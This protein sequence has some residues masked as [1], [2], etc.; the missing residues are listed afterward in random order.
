MKIRTR[1]TFQFLSLMVLVSV[2]SFTAIYVFSSAYRKEDF[3]SRLEKKANNTAKL[4]LQVDEISASLLEKIE[5]DNPMSLPEEKVIII[6]YKNE[7]VFSTDRNKTIIYDGTLLN[8]IRLERLVRFRQGEFELIGVLFISEYDRFVVIAGAHD[9]FGKSKLQNLRAVLLIVTGVIIF[10]LIFSG[11]FLAG[12]AIKPISDVVTRVED[13]NL[14]SLNVRLDVSQNM[15]EIDHLSSTFNSMLDRLESGFTMQR[16]FISNA[17]HELRTPLT[18]ITGQMEVILMKKRTTG[19][20]KASIKSSLE[21][22][23]DVNRLLNRL[24]LLA[25]TS[26]DGARFVFSRI[27]VDE[28]LWQARE[29]ILKKR[30]DY[31]II[32]NLNPNVADE[33]FLTVEGDEALLR[34]SFINLIDNGCKYSKDKRVTISLFKRRGNLNISFADNGIGIPPEDESRVLS[35]FKRGGNATAIEGHGIGLSLVSSIM[36]IHNAQLKIS[37]KVD[38][39]TTVNLIFHYPD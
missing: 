30:E 4:L 14:P 34:T 25:Q 22:I 6:D 19:E 5:M 3:Y 12:R 11:W 24:L 8:K 18:A 37:T 13:I 31:T 21:D 10:I 16:D 2:L 23:R 26:S 20:Y 9:I 33:I 32:I 1:L 15:D 29:H 38:V 39:G 28:V 36:K 7:V 35:P 17:S 27:R